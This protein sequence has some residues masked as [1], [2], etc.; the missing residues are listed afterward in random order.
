MYEL[1][2]VF[3]FSSSR[4]EILPSNDR[5]VSNSRGASRC[6]YDT[7]GNVQVDSTNCYSMAKWATRTVFGGIIGAAF[8]FQRAIDTDVMIQTGQDSI[9]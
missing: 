6:I 5:R 2:V 3:C 7:V 1:G 9:G 4:R 8:H